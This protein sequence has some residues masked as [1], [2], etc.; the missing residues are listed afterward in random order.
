[1][2]LRKPDVGHPELPAEY[3]IQTR[4]G[5]SGPF[6]Q[7]RAI[8]RPEHTREYKTGLLVRLRTAESCIAELRHIT[9]LWPG[10]DPTVRATC[11]VAPIDHDAVNSG[12]VKKD[13]YL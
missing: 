12:P 6:P 5:S 8:P 10:Y 7:Q 1:V 9:V 2:P 3:A 13:T 11:R 4:C